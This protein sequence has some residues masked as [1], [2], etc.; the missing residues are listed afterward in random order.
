ME[1]AAFEPFDDEMLKELGRLVINFGFIEFLLDQHVG[2]LFKLSSGEPRRALV[3]PLPVRR[4]LDM[5][6][7]G[8]ANIPK[9]ATRALVDDACRLVVETIDRRNDMLHGVWGMDGGGPDAKAI[10]IAP[11]KL[12]GHRK[13]SDIAPTA[14][15]FAVASRKLLDALLVDAGGEPL[16]TPE[17]LVIGLG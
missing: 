10:C 17:R 8:L 2:M 7:A 3:S 13:A 12:T 1:Q 15:A 6:R 11:K 14:D 16:R 9:P 4:K 5:L